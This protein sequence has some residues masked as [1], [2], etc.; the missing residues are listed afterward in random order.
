MDLQ[1]TQPGD[2][3]EYPAPPR[4]KPLVLFLAW[5]ILSALIGEYA[6][7]SYQELLNSLVVDAWAL[8]LCLWIR[9]LN[10]DSK[11]AFW[12]DVYLIVEIACAS[13]TIRQHPSQAVQSLIVVLGIASGVLGFATIYL[14]RYDLLKHYNEREP[15]G[16]YLGPVMT[17]FFS[18]LYF[19]SKLYEIAQF[20]ER[21][22]AGISEDPSRTLLR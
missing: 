10:P 9:R 14:I 19:Q 11:S 16:L 1:A 2:L 6:P 5:F 20:K 13:L 12:C 15:I 22:A 4:I 17:F 3:P 7:K 8:Y 18:F 21:Q